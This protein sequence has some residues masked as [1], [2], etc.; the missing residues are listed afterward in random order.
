[1]IKEKK[2]KKITL[3]IITLA[4][5]TMLMTGCNSD[6][7]TFASNKGV[8]CENTDAMEL[9]KSIVDKKFNGDF[10]IDKNNI[11]I[12]DY[13]PVGRYTCKAK[14]KRVGE[15]KAKKSTSNQDLDALMIMSQ[16]LAPAQ[17]G[18]GK[19]GGWVNY[20]TYQTTAASKKHNYFYVE[21]FSDEEGE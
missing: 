13:N 6:G 8:S 7:K 3:T 17:Y 10:E 14:I 5:S 4:L 9:L 19:E 15:Q 11:V 12:W 2:M 21:I 1:M 18:I 20:Y 16:M